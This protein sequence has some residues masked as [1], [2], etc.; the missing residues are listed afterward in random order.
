MKRV[1]LAGASW[2][3]IAT[4]EDDGYAA[5]AELCEEIAGADCVGAGDRLFILAAG[6]AQCGGEFFVWKRKDVVEEVEV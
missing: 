3:S 5:C 1:D 2:A 6:S 4:G